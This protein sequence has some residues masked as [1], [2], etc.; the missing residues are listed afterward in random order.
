MSFEMQQRLVELLLTSAV[1]ETVADVRIGL[2]YTAV[3]LASGQAGLAWTPPS[4][5]ACCTHLP[6]AGS[7]AG[8]PAEGL[9]RLLTDERSGLARAV[10]LATANALLAKSPRPVPLEEEVITSMAIGPGDHVAMVGHFGPVIA[11]LKKI[12]CR[13]EIVELRS[14]IA[15]TLDPEQGKRA[16]AECTVAILTATSLVNG[17]FDEVMASLGRP[18]QAV[19]LGPSTPLCPQAFAGTA[20]TR[21][22]GARVLDPEGVLRVVSEGGGT[23]IMKKHLGF[24]GL[25]V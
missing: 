11:D 5:A 8:Q 15:G 23:Q 20:L 25:K 6:S 13:L 17:T 7:L 22:G 3:R 9:L 12:G 2:G 1:G 21:L 10:G 19:L 18:R 4:G 14:G 24:E 16:L